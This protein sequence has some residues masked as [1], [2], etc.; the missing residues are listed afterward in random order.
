MTDEQKP[1]I[2]IEFDEYGSP[3]YKVSMNGVSSAQ[4]FIAA[5]LMQFQANNT[6]VDEQVEAKKQ[7]VAKPT[8]GILKP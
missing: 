4:L 7:A 5:G 2:F 3:H 1:F 6:F 8:E